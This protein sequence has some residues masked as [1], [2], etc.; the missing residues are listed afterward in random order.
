MSKYTD[1]KIENE[2][3][4][5]LTNSELKLFELEQ[6]FK[7]L[8]CM[9]KYDKLN[10]LGLKVIL[11]SKLKLSYKVVEGLKGKKVALEI[12]AILITLGARKKP[13]SINELYKFGFKKTSIYESVNILE[14]MGLIS[15]QNQMIKVNKKSLEERGQNQIIFSGKKRWM[16]FLLFGF[17]YLEMFNILSWK[18]KKEKLAK[19]EN[20]CSYHNCFTSAC[21]CG[22]K[23]L[24]QNNYFSNWS[25]VFVFTCLKKLVS[26]FGQK[27]NKV[28][29]TIKSWKWFE[30]GKNYYFDSN[31]KFRFEFKSERFLLLNIF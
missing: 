6:K 10:Q 22:K 11:K 7:K 16:I 31:G 29:R 1:V 5:S 27:M 3:I 25:R 26:L 9:K 23:I 18:A 12:L 24:L 8:Y 2:F 20:I 19:K 15:Y 14:K 28:F 30:N 21:G 17:N 4:L 13:F